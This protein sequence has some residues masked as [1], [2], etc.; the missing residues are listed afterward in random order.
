MPGLAASPEGSP[1]R[2]SGSGRLREVSSRSSSSE[3]SPRIVAGKVAAEE[4][5]EEVAVKAVDT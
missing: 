1:R 4:I 5:D 3:S 2:S